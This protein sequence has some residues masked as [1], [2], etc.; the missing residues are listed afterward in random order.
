M[1]PPLEDVH[2]LEDGSRVRAL[3]PT[4][5]VGEER[6][7]GPI[8]PDRTAERDLWEVEPRVLDVAEDPFAG[9]REIPHR[10]DGHGAQD[11]GRSG[12]EAVRVLQLIV[13]R[14]ETPAAGHAQEHRRGA[15][16]PRWISAAILF[17]PEVEFGAENQ[18]PAV[19][20]DIAG[21]ERALMRV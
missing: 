14:R 9:A 5:R 12:E 11:L 16:A 6:L 2:E 8:G 3:Q 4:G 20:R 18:R 13:S 1:P 7:G 21:K 17:P 19:H 15:P 10:P